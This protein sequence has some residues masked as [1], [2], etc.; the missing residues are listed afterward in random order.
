MCGGGVAAILNAM[1]ARPR[2]WAGSVGGRLMA[3]RGG[4]TNRWAIDLL[5]L[6]QLDHLIE[7]GCGSGL[8][9]EAAS[10]RLIA[11]R[12]VGIDPSRVMVDQAARRNRAAI[13][14]GHVEVRQAFA[15]ALPFE[16]HA[17]TCAL[18]VDSIRSWRSAEAG[19]WELQRVLEPGGR[20]VIVV[21][22]RQKK[23]NPLNPSREGYT[24]AMVESLETTLVSIG[25]RFIRREVR[26]KGA[27]MIAFVVE[28]AREHELPYAHGDF[29]P[30]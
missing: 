14:E 13:A 10:D 6:Q 18:S 5:K 25:F 17:F 1:F 26:R 11:G 28:A 27:T 20:L 8:A 12:A 2:G 24:R 23:R 9:L 19:L 30:A 15:E 4:D 29:V 7:V 21:R 3:L 16:D 22:A